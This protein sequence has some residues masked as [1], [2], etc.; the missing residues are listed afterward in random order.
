MRYWK[1]MVLVALLAAVAAL[2]AIELAPLPSWS[3][4]PGAVSPRCTCSWWERIVEGVPW[5]KVCPR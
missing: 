3:Q 4:E 2:L 5:C 1:K